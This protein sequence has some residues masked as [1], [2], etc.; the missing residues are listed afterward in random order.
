MFAGGT[1]VTWYPITPSSSLVENPHRL[2]EDA[3]ASSQT[4]RQ[5]TPS[6]RRK[7]SW[8]PSAWCSARLGGARSMTATSGPGISLMAEFAGLGYYAEI[9]A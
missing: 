2:H 8:P 4:A 7:T 5:P 3:T 6:C 1:V 9:P